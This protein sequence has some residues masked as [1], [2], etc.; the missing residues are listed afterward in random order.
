MCEHFF[1]LIKTTL[2]GRVKANMVAKLVIKLKFISFK[3][4][5]S[6]PTQTNKQ[7]VKRSEKIKTSIFHV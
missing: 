3:T 7:H 2:T 5:R 4:L 1:F 6:P